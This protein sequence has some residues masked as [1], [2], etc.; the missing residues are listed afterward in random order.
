MSVDD[1]LLSSSPRPP[2]PGGLTVNLNNGE[3][4]SDSETLT[5]LRPRNNNDLDERDEVTTCVTLLISENGVRTI[6]QAMGIEVID[7]R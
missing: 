4:K 2:E 3:S 6:Q 5:F 7:S 1:K